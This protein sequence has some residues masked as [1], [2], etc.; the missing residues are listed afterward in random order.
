MSKQNFTAK[1]IELGE[2]I[3]SIENRLWQ[4]VCSIECTKGGR[5][6]AGWYSGGAMEPSMKNYMVFAFSDDGGLTWEEIFGM[7][8]NPDKRQQVLDPQFWTDPS[9]KFWVFWVQRDW[10]C[11]RNHPAHLN[12]WA[13]TCDN[14]D[15][16][17]PEFTDPFYVCDGFMRNRPTVLSDGRWLLHAYNWLSDKYAYVESK[18]EGKTFEVKYAGKKVET[19]FDESMI[20]ER[21]D[22]SLLLLARADLKFGYLAKSESFDGGKT[23]TDGELTDIQNPRTRFFIQ[24]LPSGRVL[25]INNDHKD[26]RKRMVASLSEDDGKTWKYNLMLD[27]RFDVSYPDMSIGPDGSLYI[28]HDRAREVSKEVLVSRIREE[29]IISGQVLSP[30]SF[31]NNIISKAPAEPAYGK[32][33]KEAM[34]AHDTAFF[35]KYHED[36]QAG[37]IPGGE[38]NTSK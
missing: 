17:E 21:R 32:W 33:F 31:Q 29:D 15:D 16:D 19:D 13:M 28:I 18:D 10:N 9:G 30:S 22:G 3:Y 24:R 6:F 26:T 4:G 1:F 35:N 36:V 8:G 34:Q 11:Q 38:E 37:L 25:F 23:W 12:T 2:G 5:L 27:E 14:P 7:I 20:L